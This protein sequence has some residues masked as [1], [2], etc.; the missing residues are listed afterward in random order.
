MESRI[1]VY[2]N[3]LYGPRII[4]LP[5]IMDTPN[6]IWFWVHGSRARARTHEADTERNND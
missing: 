3:G 2:F 4:H 1:D 5:M 6:T